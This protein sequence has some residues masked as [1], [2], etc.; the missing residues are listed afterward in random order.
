[1]RAT[2][3]GLLTQHGDPPGWLEKSVNKQG[4]ILYVMDGAYQKRFI[5]RLLT[6][7]DFLPVWLVADK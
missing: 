2:A 7:G 1:M 6:W 5:Y 4:V 3:K